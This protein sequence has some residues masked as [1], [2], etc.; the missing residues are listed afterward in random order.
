MALGEPQQ[1]AEERHAAARLVRLE[2]A[3]G[4]LADDVGLFGDRAAGD[5]PCVRR[6]RVAADARIEARKLRG[7]AAEHEVM[8]RGEQAQLGHRPGGRRVAGEHRGDDAPRVGVVGRATHEL[9]VQP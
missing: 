1:P 4:E 5:R 6:R 3:P 8:Q 7:G 9:D 2:G